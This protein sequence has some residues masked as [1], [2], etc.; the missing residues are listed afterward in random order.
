M[1]L[2][3][4]QRLHLFEP[5]NNDQLARIQSTLRERHCRAGE[6]LFSQGDPAPHFFPGEER[7]HE[8]VPALKGW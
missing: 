8:A 6:P 5:L 4:L 7:G 2:Q 3:E 1:T